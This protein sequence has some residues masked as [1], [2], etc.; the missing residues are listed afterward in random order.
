[1]TDDASAGRP[2]PVS[3]IDTSVPHSARIWNYWLGGTD[4]YEVDRAAGDRYGETFPG[5]TGIA[6]ASR[7][8]LARSLRYL[9]AEA[10][11]RQFLDVGTGLPTADN[12][13]QLAQRVAPE[14]R[15]VYVDNDPLV[16]LHAHAL[17]TSTPEGVTDYLEADLRE[18]EDILA[19]AGRTLDLA[20][21]VA[22]ILSGILGHVADYAEA[23]S[24]VRRLMAGL[25]SG[26]YLSLN[27]GSDTDEAFR[28]AQRA[29]NESGA[30]PYHLRTPDQIGGF[31]DGLDL[32]PPGVVP[33]TRWRPDTAVVGGPPSDVGHVGGVGRKP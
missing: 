12:T 4:N 6:R 1:M 23:R 15:V 28:R 16:L 18:P 25:P 24:L 26:S 22:L 3:K 33:V 8:F 2:D 19:R 13:H 20:R 9:V 14:S 17:L 7:A 27:E 29:Y 5:I 21:P 31:F 11:M 32:V 30:V 10:G